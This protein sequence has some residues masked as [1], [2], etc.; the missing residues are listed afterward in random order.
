MTIHDVRGATPSAGSKASGQYS[1]SLVIDIAPDS[2]SRLHPSII[3]KMSPPCT[4][5]FVDRFVPR[6]G[7]Q[8]YPGF[9]LRLVAFPLCRHPAHLIYCL[10]DIAIQPRLQ[11]DFPLTSPCLQGII[12]LAIEGP[13]DRDGLI[14]LK[15]LNKCTIYWPACTCFEDSYLS[16]NDAF[17]VSLLEGSP[18]QS[19]CDL[20]FPDRLYAC[21]WPTQ[22]RTT[23]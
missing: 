5:S 20:A 22:A 6:E 7:F 10:F 12:A 17:Q 23:G 18:L 4:G 21:Y 3:V 16:D 13:L 15:R 11:T 19:S 9:E 2:R 1:T 14:V 8:H